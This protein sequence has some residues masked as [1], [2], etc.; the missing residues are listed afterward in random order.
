MMTTTGTGRA[1]GMMFGARCAAESDCAHDGGDV[2]RRNRD[3][4]AR[5]C[6]ENYEPC[7]HLK[8]DGHARDAVRSYFV[9]MDIKD[10]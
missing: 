7:W 5:G 3:V 4:W 1:S 6:R 9:T 2:R 8:D 10:I